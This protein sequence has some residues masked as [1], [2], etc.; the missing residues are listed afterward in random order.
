MSYEKGLIVIH[1]CKYKYETSVSCTLYFGDPD[2]DFS[3]NK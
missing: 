3:W 2:P 1:K